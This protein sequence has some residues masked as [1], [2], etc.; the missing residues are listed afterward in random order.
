MHQVQQGIGPR[1]WAFLDLHGLSV[2]AAQLALQNVSN[3]L[4]NLKFATHK[5]QA[6]YRHLIQVSKRQAPSHAPSK[7]FGH[8]Q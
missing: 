6:E 1:G 8:M 2:A 5:E 4:V 7:C 3:G